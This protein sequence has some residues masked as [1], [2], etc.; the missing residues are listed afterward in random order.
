[1]L[2]VFQIPL[3]ALSTMRESRRFLLS[4]TSTNNRL[5]KA[6]QLRVCPGQNLLDGLNAP[7]KGDKVLSVR[8]SFPQSEAENRGKREKGKWS[9]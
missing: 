6:S 9:F 5:T 3:I 1:M 8:A 4:S 2:T 7:V